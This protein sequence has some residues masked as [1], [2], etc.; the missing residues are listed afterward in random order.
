MKRKR[1]NENPRQTLLI[2]TA[3]QSEAL[4]FSLIAATKLVILSVVWNGG[5]YSLM[6]LNTPFPYFLRHPSLKDSSCA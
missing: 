2:V 1:V 4:Y 5:L 3:S 6:C